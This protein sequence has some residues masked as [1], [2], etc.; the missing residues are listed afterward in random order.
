[1]TRNPGAVRA[2]PGVDLVRADFDDP[3]SLAAAVAD[4]RAVFLLTAPTSP[5]PA[6][7]LAMLETA[8]SAGVTTVV[9]LSAIGTGE[10]IGDNQTVGAWHLQAEQAVRSG[11]MAWTVLRPSSFA[12]N[13][14]RFAHTINAGHPVPNTTGTATQGVIDP[15]DVAAVAAE[16][17]TTPGHAGRTYTLTGP[18]LLS[19][20]DQAAI[21]ES[22]LNRPVTTVDLP[23]DI[24]R[25]Q[26]LQHGT[27]PS[28]VD[29]AITGMAWARAG[30]NAI[31]TQDVPRILGRPAAT[32]ATWV[33]DHQDAFRP[34]P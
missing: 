28:A 17:L 16:A 31:L 3:A 10:T 18:E 25:E 5:T 34:T 4:V 14:L 13:V 15:R 7:D 9:K 30:H 21:L 26:M 33:H 6:H 22:V 29:A 12:S 2:E 19:V 11:G 20:P 32:F 23:L 1:M 27:D 8:R 24:A